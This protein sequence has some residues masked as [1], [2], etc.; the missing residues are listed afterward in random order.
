MKKFSI[1]TI[2]VTAFVLCALYAAPLTLYADAAK[3]V[4]QEGKKDL[5]IAY[6]KAMLSQ[7]DYQTSGCQTKNQKLTADINAWIVAQNDAIKKYGLE[8]GTLFNV[9]LEKGVDGV[10]PV[11]PSPVPV[12]LPVPPKK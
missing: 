10:V 5:L 1:L 4:P 6:Q 2:A 3:T 12:P 9:D 11:A 8:P 7:Q